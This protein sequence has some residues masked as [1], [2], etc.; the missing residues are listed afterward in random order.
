MGL[1]NESSVDEIPSWPSTS[2]CGEAAHT[3]LL[4]ESPSLW[5][6][7]STGQIPG[8]VGVLHM[9]D[10]WGLPLEYGDT[11]EMLA[12]LRD[13]FEKLYST[14]WHKREMHGSCH[15]LAS[16]LGSSTGHQCP[17]RRWGSSQ[18]VRRSESGE[19]HGSVHYS[20]NLGAGR[21]GG[22]IG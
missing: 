17:A 4:H 9:S 19:A 12:A 5:K 2:L 13:L 8:W 16:T 3:R 7:A 18:K 22:K 21:Q 11:L 1:G 20:A 6:E 15:G 10:A 14:L